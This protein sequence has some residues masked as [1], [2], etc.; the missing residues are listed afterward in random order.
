MSA[1]YLKPRQTYSESYGLRPVLFVRN[2]RVESWALIAEYKDNRSVVGRRYGEATTESKLQ[3]AANRMKHAIRYLMLMHSKLAD[4][5]SRIG[6]I[7][8]DAFTLRL[9]Y[10]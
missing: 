9:E 5:E 2:D 4:H 6:G 3:M 8:L 7:R 1:V 10:E